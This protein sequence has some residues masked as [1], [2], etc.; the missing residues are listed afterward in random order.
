MTTLIVIETAEYAGRDLSVEG[1]ILG[2]GVTVRRFTYTGNEDDLIHAC[3]GAD[4]ILTDYTPFSAHVI[5]P[6]D[7]CTLI[8]VAATGYGV[9][10]AG[11]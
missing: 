5:D 9:V 8:S 2:P 6:L 11:S 10:G 4:C 3:R 7:V 1:D